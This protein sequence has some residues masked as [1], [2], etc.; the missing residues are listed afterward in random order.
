VAGLVGSVGA[1]LTLIEN[2]Y[3]LLFGRL[4]LGLTGGS[5]GVIAIPFIY[6][7]VPV[8]RQS[9]CIATYLV[10]GNFGSLIALFSGF[11]LPKDDDV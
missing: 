6:E 2:F 8:N 9:E 1:G 11:I 3:V 4:I 7:Y 10:I 5:I